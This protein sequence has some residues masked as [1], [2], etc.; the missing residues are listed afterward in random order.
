MS[1]GTVLGTLLAI[2]VVVFLF[3][4]LTMAPSAFG[5]R[6]FSPA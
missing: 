1:I 6:R 5:S 2:V 3:V 4:I